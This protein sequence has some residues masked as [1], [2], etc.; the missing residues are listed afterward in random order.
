MNPPQHTHYESISS[1][2]KAKSQAIREFIH[3]RRASQAMDDGERRGRGG[4]SGGGI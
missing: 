3:E 4:E 2:S 1:S